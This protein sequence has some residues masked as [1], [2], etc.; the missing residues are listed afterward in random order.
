MSDAWSKTV[1]DV[2]VAKRALNAHRL[3]RA[4]RLEKIP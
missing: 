4:I 2:R 1:I 3:Q